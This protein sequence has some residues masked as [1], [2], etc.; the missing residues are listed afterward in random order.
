MLNEIF[1]KISCRLLL[2]VFA[3]LSAQTGAVAQVYQTAAKHAYLIDWNSGSVLF[4]KEEDEQ[5]PPASMAKLMT[6]EVV[7]HALK[8]GEL[9]LDSEFYI[10]EHAWRDGGANSG[11]FHH[12]RQIGFHGST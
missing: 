11:G 9:T 1:K 7:F 5:V 6:L 8:T 12:V 10:S 2:L 3:T 4:S